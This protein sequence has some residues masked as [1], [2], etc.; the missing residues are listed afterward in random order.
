M[1]F[2]INNIRLSYVGV[3]PLVRRES[4]APVDPDIFAISTI[5]SFGRPSMMLL[6]SVRERSN[7]PSR[8][9][10][11][12]FWQYLFK[13]LLVSALTLNP[14]FFASSVSIS[15]LSWSIRNECPIVLRLSF[16][17]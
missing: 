17:I 5:F 4:F 9:A 13:I 10:H 12:Q 6:T 7:S 3:T 8:S 14:C 15:R 16:V 11:L 1:L 2:L